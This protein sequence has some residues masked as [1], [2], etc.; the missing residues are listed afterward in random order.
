MHQYRAK[1]PKISILPLTKKVYLN[2]NSLKWIW[3]EMIKWNDCSNFN[4]HVQLF[5][6]S[7][8]CPTY[9]IAD[10]KWLQH[11]HYLLLLLFIVVLQLGRW[12]EMLPTYRP[13]YLSCPAYVLELVCFIRDWKRNKKHLYQFGGQSFK[14]FIVVNYNSR[15]KKSKRKL[16]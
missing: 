3:N 16:F 10:Q 13:T 4:E 2:T 15:E 8:A 1:V 14:Y 12:N 6:A 5:F 7:G 11:H 9:F